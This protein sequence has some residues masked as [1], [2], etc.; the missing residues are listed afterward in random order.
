MKVFIRV[1]AILLVAVVLF[2]IN[3]YL[4]VDRY[5][6]NV[7][8]GSFEQKRARA[9]SVE[10]EKFIVIGGSASNLGFDSQLFE[11]LAGKP[12]VNLSV[13]AGV[14]LRVYMRAAELC[15]K[16]GDIILFP[17]EYGYYKDEFDKVSEDYVDIVAVDGDLRCDEG[18][19]NQMDYLVS[20]FLRSYTRIN[21]CLLFDLRT[22]MGT[23]NTIYVADSV[24]EY[25]D[26]CLHKDREPTYLCAPRDD[27]FE[28]NE[29]TMEE[30]ARFIKEM[31]EKGV[32][33]YVTYPCVDKY[34][35][36]DY[37]RYFADAQKV[38]E[39]YVPAAN[40]LGTP[41][42]FAYESDYFFDTAYH[43]RYENRAVYT[44]HLFEQYQKKTE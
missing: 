28:Y 24:N 33:V 12:A 10:G 3:D 27:P 21:D 35:F 16:E 34:N 42:D 31:G 15:A 4:T 1:T 19:A 20:R 13:S 43:L 11:E 38:I 41:A 36:E 25:G 17:I 44:G 37:E 14:P 26:F 30:I 29:D 32:H 7:M 22:I 6:E 8:Y 40:I 5:S 39:S 23:E 2:M 9:E 18:V